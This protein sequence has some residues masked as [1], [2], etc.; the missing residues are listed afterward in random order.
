MPLVSAG[1]AW[2][3]RAL[4]LQ[5]WA[6]ATSCH[7]AINSPAFRRFCRALANA[8]GRLRGFICVLRPA[9]VVVAQLN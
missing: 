7:S 9:P 8:L 6:G 3:E 1:K 4:V 2:G 5:A